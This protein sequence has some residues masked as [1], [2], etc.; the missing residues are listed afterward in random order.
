[1][2]IALYS[3][4]LEVNEAAAYLTSQLKRNISAQNIYQLAIDNQIRI[5]VKIIGPQSALIESKQDNQIKPTAHY[6]EQDTYQTLS[7]TRWYLSTTE[8]SIQLLEFLERYNKKYDYA[9]LISS[10]LILESL[11]CTKYA[12]LVYLIRDGL[13]THVGRSMSFPDDHL[14]EVARDDLDTLIEKLTIKKP[15]SHKALNENEP[16]LLLVGALSEALS[17][18]NPDLERSGKPNASKIRDY[19]VDTVFEV[20]PDEGKHPK[21]MGPSTVSRNIK[22]GL[23]YLEEIDFSAIDTNELF[24]AIKTSLAE[25]NRKKG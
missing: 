2:T 11:D 4:W 19:L 23:N 25:V 9:A 15:N 18:L 20:D 21:G 1:M 10:P 17:K 12:H 3:S 16:L 7:G 6:S 14:L 5:A 22:L 8:G 13:K 24:E